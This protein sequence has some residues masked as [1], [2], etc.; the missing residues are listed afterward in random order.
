M[1]VSGIVIV[2]TPQDLALSDVRRACKMFLKMNVP[3]LGVVENMS[4]HVCSH[5]GHADAIFGE[6]GAE[7]L[8][9]QYQVPLLG[10]LPLMIDVRLMS[11][12]G[13][14]PVIKEPNGAI[15]TEF[16]QIAKSIKNKLDAQPKSYAH[17]FP[18]IV[19][20]KKQ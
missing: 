15:A 12:S 18:K 8:A 20:E 2:T 13:V 17:L 10:S 4:T 16:M 14:P 3:I 11:D 1:A 5:C 6:G 9:K 7:H 19:E